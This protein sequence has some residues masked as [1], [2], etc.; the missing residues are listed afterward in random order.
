MKLFSIHKTGVKP[1]DTT[2]DAN[3]TIVSN[4][5]ALFTSPLLI[6]YVVFFFLNQE[7]LYSSVYLILTIFLISTLAFNKLHKHDTAKIVVVVSS[8]VT[9]FVSVIC[10]GK[11]AQ[12]HN[13]LCLLLIFS[14][15]FFTS[16]LSWTFNVT[17]IF[18]SYLFSFYYVNNFGP[19]APELRFQFDD[20]MNFGFGLL[21]CL[22][23]SSLIYNS[24]NE[25]FVEISNK[26][27]SLKEKNEELEKNRILIESQ[28][29]ELELFS[30]MVS[31]D[32]KTPVRTINAFIDLSKKS[33]ES[34]NKEEL[35]K[36]LDFALKGSD[37][38]NNLVSRISDFKKLD[39]TSY[40]KE[41]VN[42]NK[43][44]TDIKNIASALNP[45]IVWKLDNF[46]S[47]NA[48]PFHIIK[49]FEN[50][51]ENALKYNENNIKK[52]TINNNSSNDQL[53]ISI[54]DNGIGIQEEYKEYIFEPFKK[55]HPNHVYDSA[56]MGLSICKKIVALYQGELTLKE[57]KIQDGSIFE[58]V[59]PKAIC[60]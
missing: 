29:N 44:I 57:N 42:L 13:F 34:G 46:P 59:F 60:Q 33:I 25:Q 11:D 17:V 6:F 10:F 28:K 36:Y 14:Y 41:V 48:N 30:S 38:L 20:Y 49:L 3:K 8:A 37:Q 15:I 56:G 35:N 58:I 26:N 50:L 54:S 18:C 22:Y 4:L 53:I 1:T 2:I 5:I 40:E 32:L 39:D 27:E 23:F 51:I 45:N 21:C 19:L 12:A 47:I 9:V 31:H 52:I 7:Y 55:L 16:A 43:V 24:I